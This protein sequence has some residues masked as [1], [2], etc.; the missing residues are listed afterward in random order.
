MVKMS[1]AIDKRRIRETLLANKERSRPVKKESA[2]TA[3]YFPWSV[4]LNEATLKRA[5]LYFDHIYLLAP[6]EEKLDAF[7]SELLNPERASWMRSPGLHTNLRNSISTFYSNIEP[8]R[9]AGIIKTLDTNKPLTNEANLAVLETLCVADVLNYEAAGIKTDLPVEV[10]IVDRRLLHVR[11]VRDEDIAFHYW[12]RSV[13]S[14]LHPRIQ[15]QITQFI[16]DL[17]PTAQA[18]LRNDIGDQ[19]AAITRALLLNASVL[20]MSEAGVTPLVDDKAYF[21]LLRLKYKS[22]FDPMQTENAG[23]NTR[24]MQEFVAQAATKAGLLADLVLEVALPNVDYTNLH[25]VLELRDYFRDELGVFRDSMVAMA[26]RLKGSIA[27][28]EFLEEAQLLVASEIMPGLAELQRKVRFSKLKLLREFVSGLMSL[29]PTVPFVV[30]AFTPV[31]LYVAALV[32]AGVMTLEAAIKQYIEKQELLYNNGLAYVFN[33]DK[34]GLGTPKLWS[35]SSAWAER[36][37]V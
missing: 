25:D 13:I 18:F 36:Y 35:R 10:A 3:A 6:E 26:A 34:S 17:P 21:D 30:S 37:R 20:C 2:F 7:L 8:L 1:D 29:K 5:L 16:S 15:T 22:L 32:A 14:G 24:S 19:S 9:R 11:E 27:D 23:A 33:L 31:P 4:I 12:D 28:P